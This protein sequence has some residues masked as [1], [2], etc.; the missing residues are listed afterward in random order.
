MSSRGHVSKPPIL[1]ST[2]AK[3]SKMTKFTSV[4]S[5][6]W[7]L[8][9]AQQFHMLLRVKIVYIHP[10]VSSDA[11]YVTELIGETLLRKLSQKLP[12]FKKES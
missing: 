7:K 6:S 1:Q 10:N 4:D 9:S 11:V 2:L 3:Q 8:R 5:P 12:N